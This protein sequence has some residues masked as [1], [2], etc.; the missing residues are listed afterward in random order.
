MLL[1]IYISRDLG[2]IIP[3][4]KLQNYEYYLSC[5]MSFA[6]VVHLPLS[7]SNLWMC[8]YEHGFIIMQHETTYNIHLTTWSAF[9]W[10][11][12][13]AKRNNK[14]TQKTHNVCMIHPIPNN[15]CTYYSGL[16]HWTKHLRQ[17]YESSV[18]NYLLI[19]LLWLSVTARS[20]SL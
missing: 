19:T 16:H 2:Y 7:C 10:Q 15:T 6:H 18:Q 3:M 5:M 20:T 17:L 1:V 11:K 12:S 8:Q 4:Y 14:K 9:H 13:N